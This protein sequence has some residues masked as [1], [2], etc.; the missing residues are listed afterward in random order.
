[1]SSFGIIKAEPYMKCELCGKVDETRPYGPKGERIC[2]DCGMKDEAT[3]KRKMGIY[4]LGDP[5]DEPEK[6]VG[7][8]D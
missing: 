6:G 4:L 2:F 3:T 5:P 7:G 8:G 1:M